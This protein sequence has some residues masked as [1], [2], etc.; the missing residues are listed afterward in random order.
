M[1][2]TMTW[3]SVAPAVGEIYLVAAICGILLIDVFLGETR[4]AAA[5]LLPGPQ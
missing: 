1:F 2:E 4:P 3:A 5:H